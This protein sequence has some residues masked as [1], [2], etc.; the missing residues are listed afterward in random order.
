MTVSPPASQAVRRERVSG[1]AL[2]MRGVRLEA[3]A[4][5]DDVPMPAHIKP[6]QVPVPRRCSRCC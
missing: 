5:V 1:E 4:M 2:A 3:E 6:G